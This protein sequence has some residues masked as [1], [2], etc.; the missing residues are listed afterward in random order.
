VLIT[1]LN[2]YRDAFPIEKNL[3]DV[4]AHLRTILIVIV[5]IADVEWIEKSKR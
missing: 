1:T 5:A 3:T 4:F 2:T